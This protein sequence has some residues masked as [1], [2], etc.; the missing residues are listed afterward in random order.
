M[1]KKI[2]KVFSTIFIMYCMLSLL[3]PVAFA[4]VNPGALNQIEM[5]S[6]YVE[7]EIAKA[8][9]MAEKEALKNQS[10]EELNAALDRIIDELIVKTEKRVN[11]VIEKA[12]KEGIEL[13]KVYVEV[14]ILDR[15]VYVDP[16]FAH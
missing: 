13:T 11:K 5:S 14:Q 4:E 9:E 7:Q 8:I 12:S 10:E 2:K 16:L 6:E 3:T 15:V 1:Y